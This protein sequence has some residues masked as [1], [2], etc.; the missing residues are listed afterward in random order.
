MAPCLPTLW[1][2]PVAEYLLLQVIVG[3]W[4]WQAEEDGSHDDDSAPMSFVWDRAFPE[5]GLHT[6]GLIKRGG[7]DSEGDDIIFA[8]V[9][10]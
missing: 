8:E 1:L 4:Y 5:G 3:L 2:A 9:V 10:L 7:I 6:D